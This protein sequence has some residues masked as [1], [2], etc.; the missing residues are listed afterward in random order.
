[1]AINMFFHL[2]PSMMRPA[3]RS[4]IDLEGSRRELLEARNATFAWLARRH[5]WPCLAASFDP[6]DSLDQTAA[7]RKAPSTTA[8]GAR[9]RHSSGRGACE[10][11]CTEPC[12]SR[13]GNVHIECGACSREV[14]CNPQAVDFDVK[15]KDE[16]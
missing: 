16:L 14:R 6:T 10:A 2:Q 13:N 7:C 15:A 4:S 9:L 3:G 12:S 5:G 1:M 11:Y 8:D